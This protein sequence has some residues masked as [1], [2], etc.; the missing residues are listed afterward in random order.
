M[1]RR[2]WATEPDTTERLSPAD[3]QQQR[4][5]KYSGCKYRSPERIEYQ[6]HLAKKVALQGIMYE[7]YR[8]SSVMGRIEQDIE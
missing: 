2:A 3:T 4:K 8:M 5:D 6:L 1:D 7:K